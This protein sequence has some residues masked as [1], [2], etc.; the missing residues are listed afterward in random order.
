M[1]TRDQTL[2]TKGM[3][4]NTLI[5]FSSDNGGPI[6]YPASGASCG[7]LLAYTQGCRL[8]GVDGCCSQTPTVCRSL[9]EFIPGALWALQETTGPSAAG[10]WP[11]GKV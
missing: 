6:Y 1:S 11:T 3:Y 5:F 7:I 9:T 2:K 10:R 4:N 8:V